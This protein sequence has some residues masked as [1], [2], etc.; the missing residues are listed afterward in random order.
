MTKPHLDVNYKPSIQYLNI[1][2][3][4]KVSEADLES[5]Y[6]EILEFLRQYS[7]RRIMLDLSKREKLEIAGGTQK[8]FSAIFQE[9]LKAIDGTL[10]LA[11]VLSKEEYFLTSEGSLFDKMNSMD[12]EFVITQLFSNCEAAQEWLLTAQ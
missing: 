8:L 12:N 10:F 6:N 4:G 9:A 11:M 1:A 7:V 2:W 5:G 3:K